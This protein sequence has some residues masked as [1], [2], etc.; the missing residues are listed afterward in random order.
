M[1]ISMSICVYDVYALLICDVYE[2]G[3]GDVYVL[4]KWGSWQSW[5]VRVRLK[6]VQ[7]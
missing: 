7:Q 6:S 3:N 4:G 5:S 2:M 1:S